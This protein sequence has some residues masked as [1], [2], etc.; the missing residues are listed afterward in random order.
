MA[1]CRLGLLVLAETPQRRQWIYCESFSEGA[2]KAI[3]W[4]KEQEG[5]EA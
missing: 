4:A 2:D 1:R 3:A 5:G